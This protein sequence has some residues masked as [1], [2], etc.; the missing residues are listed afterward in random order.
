M[1]TTNLKENINKVINNINDKSFLEAVYT[2][3]ADKAE[4]LNCQLTP[5]IKDKLDAREDS[6]KKGKSKSYSWQNVKKAALKNEIMTATMD[7]AAIRRELHNYLEVAADKKVK[8]I[9]TMMESA[10]KESAIEYTDEL[11]ATLEQRYADYENGKAK[12]VTAIESRRRIRK[13]LTES[14]K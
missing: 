13:I 14:H 10:I 2:I 6:H 5:A 7:T 8:A 3:V 4:E 9:Y 12:T 11:K 1:T